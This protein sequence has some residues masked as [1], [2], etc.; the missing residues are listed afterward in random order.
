ML[1]KDEK[2]DHTQGLIRMMKMVMDFSAIELHNNSK[3][4]Y[5]SKFLS[6][7]K[8]G[9]LSYNISPKKS[10]ELNFNG[11]G[12]HG[13]SDMVRLGSITEKSKEDDS[14]KVSADNIPLP[15]KDSINDKLV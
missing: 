10:D 5:E 12:T 14:K 9:T 3:K 11:N 4:E 15:S 1:E 2:N 8:N 7:S 6:G 13:M